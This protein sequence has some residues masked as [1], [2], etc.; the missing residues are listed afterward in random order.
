M[1]KAALFFIYN[2]L[3]LLG[4][5]VFVPYLAWRFIT[6]KEGRESLLGK[7]GFYAGEPPPKGGIDRKSTRLNSS[8]ND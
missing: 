8:H 5:P 3:L 2:L 4:L 7:S 1:K 6:G